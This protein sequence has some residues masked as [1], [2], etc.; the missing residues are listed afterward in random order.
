M[1]GRYCRDNLPTEFYVNSLLDQE[2]EVE[3]RSSV[4]LPLFLKA[5][6][7]NTSYLNRLGPLD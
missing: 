4:Q 3:L 7:L 1:P 6:I 2:M 5:A